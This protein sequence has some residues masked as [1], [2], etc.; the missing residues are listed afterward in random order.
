MFAKC[1]RGVQIV[2]NTRLKKQKSGQ[3]EHAAVD[4]YG[5]SFSWDWVHGD[6][7]LFYSIAV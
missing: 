4:P 6:S 2:R 7:H 3:S 1:E 5:D